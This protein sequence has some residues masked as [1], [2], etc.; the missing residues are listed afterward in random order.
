MRESERLKWHLWHGNVHQAVQVVQSVEADADVAGANN[1]AGAARKLYKV[2]GE[3]HT[4]I[5]NNKGFMPN[6]GER[7]RVGERISTALWSPQ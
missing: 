7:Y 4:Y 3:F 6:D 2:V 5:E 1:G